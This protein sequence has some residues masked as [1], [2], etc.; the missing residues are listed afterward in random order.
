MS[1]H[2]SPHF[3]K[4]YNVLP[5][6]IR[7]LAD[8][9]FKLLQK[10]PEHPSLHLKTVGRYRSARVGSRHRV[11]AVEVEDGLLW[12]WIGDHDGYERLLGN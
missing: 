11:L 5:E 1:H 6:Q 10:D 12:F 9:N 3:W 7:E 8:K 2:A 4:L